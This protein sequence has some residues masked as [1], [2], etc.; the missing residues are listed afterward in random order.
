MVEDFERNACL[1]GYVVDRGRGE[2]KRMMV[3]KARPS[4]ESLL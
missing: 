3:M 1:V 2:E 4:T